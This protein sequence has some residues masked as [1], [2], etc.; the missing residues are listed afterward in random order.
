[1]KYLNKV[2]IALSLVLAACS[3]GGGG[4]PPDSV[5]N[6]GGNTATP[7]PVPASAKLEADR[8][9]ISMGLSNLSVPR[10]ASVTIKNTGGFQTGPLIV[11]IANGGSPTFTVTSSTCATF[12]LAPQQT[13]TVNLQLSSATANGYS[14][15]LFVESGATQLSV[16]LTGYVM[17]YADVRSAVSEI[18]AAQ[19]QTD[20]L[21]GSWPASVEGQLSSHAVILD[22][23]VDGRVFYSEAQYQ[24]LYNTNFT[25]LPKQ[26]WKTIDKALFYLAYNDIENEGDPYTLIRFDPDQANT[27]ANESLQ[28]WNLSE[29]QRPRE[30]SASILYV[31]NKAYKLT[32]SKADLPN[33]SALM[34]KY[35]GA[36]RLIDLGGNQVSPRNDM[37]AQMGYYFDLTR[38]VPADHYLENSMKEINLYYDYFNVTNDSVNK[39]TMAIPFIIHWEES[40][41]DMTAGVDLS[42]DYPGVQS[43]FNL[44]YNPTEFVYTSGKTPLTHP[45]LQNL[46]SLEF[47]DTWSFQVFP[48]SF[49]C[50]DYSYA[51]L[52]YVNSYNN[53]ELTGTA[54]KT[55]LAELEVAVQSYLP[56]P[57]ICNRQSG[58]Y[59]PNEDEVD[60]NALGVIFNMYSKAPLTTVP[61]ATRIAMFNQIR[62]SLATNGAL[63]GANA[64]SL[65]KAEAIKA[66]AELTK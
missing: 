10:T 31:L 48:N 51:L 32:H 39:K 9:L 13:C 7:T 1:M 24:A 12:Q 23:L 26:N 55:A 49:S 47:I 61:V 19:N 17:D 42:A 65:S 20:V 56:S 34:T 66:L 62:S 43:Q 37:L 63:R 58:V 27:Q 8:P 22:A 4:A 50:R 16:P 3:G 45:D 53:A 59:Q 14:S 52:N 30:V 46:P 35:I 29:Y 21:L 40:V 38:P 5:G 64:N 28:K 25:S 41:E 11:R 33:Y 15:F 18:S 54:Q 57:S 6:N 2:A 60:D 36:R 44:R